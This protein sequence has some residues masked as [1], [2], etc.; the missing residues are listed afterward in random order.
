[1]LSPPDIISAALPPF[2]VSWPVPPVI[3]KAP[4]VPVAAE[5]S[6]VVFSPSLEVSTAFAAPVELF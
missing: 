6:I 2:K 3:V 5:T 4:L 1:M